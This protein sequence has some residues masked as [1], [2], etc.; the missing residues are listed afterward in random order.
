MFKSFTIPRAL[1]RLSVR[2]KLKDYLSV[3]RSRDEKLWELHAKL[4]LIRSEMRMNYDSYDYGNGY[5]YQSMR[6]INLSGHRNTEDRIEQL[7]LA[8]RV[9]NKT[10]LDI[11]SNSGFLLLSLSQ[12]IKNGIGIEINDYLVSTG[13]AVKNYLNITNVELI[14]GTFE[15]YPENNSQFD[16]I[17]S[18]ANH[19][20]YDGNTKQSVDSYFRK[21][22]HLLTDEGQVIFE[23]HPPEIEPIEKLN[24]TICIIEKYFII[25][26]KPNLNLKGFLDKNRYYLIARKNN[27]VEQ[28]SSIFVASISISPL[29]VWGNTIGIVV[30]FY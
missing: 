25:E 27:R 10:V 24:Q 14:S 4:E 19:C 3:L 12:Y 20:T 9:A 7:G 23:S 15:D 8:Q 26:E 28:I 17:L 21:I 30:Y 2:N 13:L 5:Y 11:G 1:D 16:I 6:R 22:A 29:L 18:L